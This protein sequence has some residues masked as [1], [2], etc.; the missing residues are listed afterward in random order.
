M[1]LKGRLKLIADKTPTCNI[2]CDIGTDH[3]YIPIFLVRNGR[4]KGQLHVMCEKGL[5]RLQKAM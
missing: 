5:F 1:E 2:L 3:A 4:C